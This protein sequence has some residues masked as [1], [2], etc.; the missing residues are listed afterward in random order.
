MARGL[1]RVP[2]EV[3]PEREPRQAQRRC[4]P[5]TQPVPV[6]E[7]EKQYG[8]D[9]QGDAEPGRDPASP[10]DTGGQQ[11]GP[12]GQSEDAQRDDAL[13]EPPGPAQQHPRPLAD[14]EGEAAQQC[15]PTALAAGELVDPGKP[16]D[17]AEQSDRQ[18]ESGRAD[19]EPDGSVGGSGDDRRQAPADPAEAADGERQLCPRALSFGHITS[20]GGGP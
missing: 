13:G 12:A 16:E 3:A 2:E 5:R 20:L 8:S 14:G 10:D 9:E 17:D 6:P 7:P 1:L 4:E 19:E 18:Y 11:D 15:E